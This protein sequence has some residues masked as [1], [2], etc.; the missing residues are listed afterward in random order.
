MRSLMA[1]EVLRTD[2]AWKFA[3]SSTTRVVFSLMALSPP[4]ITPASAMAPRGVGDHQVRRL[5]RVFLVVQRAE[6]LARLR[7]AD[8][9]RVALQ[10]VRVERVHRLR[11]FGHDEV[12][13]VDDVVDRVQPDRG[14]PVLQ[15][16]AATA[17]P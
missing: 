5:E 15:P 2:E 11:Q 14:Q 12:R 4:P 13:H 9:D 3:L 8:E 17:A 16:Q 6:A 1:D 10:Q 7:R